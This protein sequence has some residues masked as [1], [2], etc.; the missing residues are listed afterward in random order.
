M[1]WR[2]RMSRVNCSCSSLAGDLG[3]DRSPETYRC[4][5][6]RCNSWL[7]C[8]SRALLAHCRCLSYRLDVPV[9]FCCLS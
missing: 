3:G 9:S 5:T 6:C 7:W 8:W 4:P 1:G 2:S